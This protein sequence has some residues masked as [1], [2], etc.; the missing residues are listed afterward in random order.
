MWWLLGGNRLRQRGVLGINRRNADCILQHNPRGRIPIVDDKLLMA[1]LC[2]RIGIPAPPIFAVI[3]THA[4][5]RSLP[6]MLTGRRE[7]VAKPARGAGGRGILVCTA[8]DGDRFRRANGA[9]FDLDDLRAHVSDSLTGMYSLDGLPDRVLLQQRVRAHPL[10]HPIAPRGLADIRIVLYRFEPAMA[11]LRLPT[12]ASNGRA[13]LHQGGIGVGVDLNTG[14][15]HHAFLRNESIDRHPDTGVPILD[16]TIPGWGTILEMARTTARA[17]GLGFVGID[18]V[19][20]EKTGPLLL[21][22]NAR[23]GLGIQ[24]ANGCGLRQA[25]AAID[26]AS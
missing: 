16:W 19:I 12:L 3:S 21:E 20:D 18:I 4:E 9:W 6:E 14:R 24:L 2:A 11:M 22:A 8:R 15:T 5:L 23:P 26:S 10:F 17:V 25:M 1:E 7:F 13:N